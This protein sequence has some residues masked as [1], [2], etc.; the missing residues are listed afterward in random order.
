M[1]LAQIAFNPILIL[2]P[3]GIG[4]HYLLKRRKADI[5]A[6]APASK[7]PCKGT[8][9]TA[10]KIKV[11]KE[12]INKK[13]R[14]EPKHWYMYEEANKENFEDY[15]GYL[16]G[17]FEAS[18]G[19]R[20]KYG[21]PLVM[22]VTPVFCEHHPGEL[23]RIV[24]TFVFAEGEEEGEVW[25]EISIEVPT[26]KDWNEQAWMD[27]IVH[28]REYDGYTVVIEVRDFSRSDLKAFKLAVQDLM[29]L[30]EL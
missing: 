24:V 13:I 5:E 14:D 28:I 20:H 30:L 1:S 6:P 22:E 3:F 8:Q 15:W 19:H 21:E 9:M 18:R 26:E 4:M 7:K 16:F 17:G 10:K 11:K 25:R 12:D 2:A 29:D 27:R 23:V